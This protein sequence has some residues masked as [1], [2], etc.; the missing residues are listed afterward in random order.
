MKTVFMLLSLA[1]PRIL[2]EEHRTSA[3]RSHSGAWHEAGLGFVQLYESLPRHSPGWWPFRR[4]IT[5]PLSC[6]P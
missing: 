2:G 6:C 5:S 4:Q 3:T 1:G